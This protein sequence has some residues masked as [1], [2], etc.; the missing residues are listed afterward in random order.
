MPDERCIADHDLRAKPGV[1]GQDP[2]IAV[3]G[4]PLDVS[5]LGHCVT[6]AR[7][8]PYWRLERESPHD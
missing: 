7:R 5:E 8:L 2:L 4:V 3:F 1:V 6:Q